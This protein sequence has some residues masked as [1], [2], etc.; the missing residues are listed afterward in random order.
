MLTVL[1]VTPDV[2]LFTVVCLAS[3][4]LRDEITEEVIALDEEVIVTVLIG[5]E[6]VE[7]I[8]VINELADISEEY[9]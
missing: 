2:L 5:L 6:D 4:E 3:R 8:G 9:V 7:V 1:V